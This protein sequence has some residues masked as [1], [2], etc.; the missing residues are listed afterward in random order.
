MFAGWCRL[1]VESNNNN[2][3]NTQNNNQNNITALFSPPTISLC[4]VNATTYTIQVCIYVK[5]TQAA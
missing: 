4:W 2:N 1:R 5:P 3:N